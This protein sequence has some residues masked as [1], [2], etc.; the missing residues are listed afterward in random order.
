[1]GLQRLYVRSSGSLLH[2]ECKQP[3]LD[4]DRNDHAAGC[5]RTNALGKLHVAQ[6]KPAGGAG[7][8]PVPGQRVFLHIGGLQRSRRS[9]L[10]RGRGNSGLQRIG[11]AECGE[12]AAGN[13]CNQHGHSHE[14]ERIQLGYDAE[15]FRPA[16]RC[17][18]G[19]L[20]QPGYS[21][22]ERQR[23]VNFDVHC[24]FYGDDWDE[25]GDDYRDVRHNH[26]DNDR[27]VD[28]DIPG[29]RADGG[30]RSDVK[31]A[32]MRD[33]RLVL[34]LG[35][36]PASGPG[37]DVGRRRTE[38]TQQHQWSVRGRYFRNVPFR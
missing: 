14:S 26:C 19:I 5:R 31:G 29:R 25:H 1:M 24:F 23:D 21:S 34:R 9:D 2:R 6:R 38:S 28:G 10:R 7:A 27:L 17:D 37:Y 8:I 36:K 3:N 32:E 11:V 30:L 13:E 35:S 16:E 20:N 22:G 4:P 18:G 12:R 15:C 33:G